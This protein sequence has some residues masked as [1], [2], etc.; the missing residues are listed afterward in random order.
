MKTMNIPKYENV[1]KKINIKWIIKKI[2]QNQRWKK[3][4]ESK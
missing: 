2:K 3:I 4:D 1:K